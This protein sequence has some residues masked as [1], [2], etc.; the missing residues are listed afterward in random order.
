MNVSI[1][2][3][4]SPFSTLLSSH[5]TKL[6]FCFLS[7]Q[8]MIR[9]RRE[10]LMSHPL[11]MKYLETKWY[12]QTHFERSLSDSHFRSSLK[13][14]VWNVFPF[15]QSGHLHCLLGRL[16]HRLHRVDVSGK[17]QPLQPF[18]LR[19]RP[20]GWLQLHQGDASHQPLSGKR[21]YGKWDLRKGWSNSNTW[22]LI[23][24]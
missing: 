10:E 13:E 17:Q 15:D 19:S 22:I 11:C 23:K 5:S 9:Y 2:T 20:R 3:L 24:F 7:F 21:E 6:C 18:Q 8:L 14:C 12:L 16:D 4:R 1:P